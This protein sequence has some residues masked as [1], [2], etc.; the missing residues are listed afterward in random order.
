MD[1]KV[2]YAWKDLVQFGIECLTGEACA[3]SMR[4]LCDVN[5]AGKELLSDYFGMP[6][7]AL[8]EP[9]N[10]RVN[11]E[12][13]IGSVMLSRECLSDLATFA[14]FREGALAVVRD[15]GMGLVG[16][17]DPERLQQYAEAGFSLCRNPKVGSHAPTVGSRN[18]HVM[19]GR[20]V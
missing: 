14:M 8:A 16:V 19:T 10:S 12:P 20:A 18:V 4:L 6:N 3:F 5:E 17:Y 9:W 2:V 11:Q 15:T 1:T 13:A 7:I